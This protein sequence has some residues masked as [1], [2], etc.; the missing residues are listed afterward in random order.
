MSKVFLSHSSKDKEHFV[1][2]VANKLNKKNVIY[3]EYSFEEGG[4]TTY[5]K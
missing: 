2:K 4:K 3:D 5:L 1:S